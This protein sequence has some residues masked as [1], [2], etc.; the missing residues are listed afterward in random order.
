VT[1]P[2]F[3]RDLYQGTAGYYD[4]C[5]LPYPGALTDDLAHRSGADGTGRLLD[6]AC[7]TGQVC[8]TLLDRFAEVW[9]VDQEPEMIAVVRDK[10]RAAGLAHVRAVAAPAEGLAAPEASF[11]LVTIGNAFHRLPRDAVA[12]GVFRWL[13]PGG[14][15][16][17]VWSRPPWDGQQPWQRALAR[18][19]DRWQARAGAGD[20]I[21]AGYEQDRRE[22]PDQVI[23]AA[24]GFETAG[25]YQFPA[26]HEWTPEALA[27]FALST[28][29]L[30]AAALGTM[31]AG[32]GDDLR[33]ELH[34]CEPSGRLPQTIDFA[35]N[36]ARRP[37]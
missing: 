14:L 27:G 10:A 37:A 33:R 22:R 31:A 17:L 6:L 12:A 32:F 1:G 23:L 36:L 34:A 4:R 24:A 26:R 16:A 18:T 29:V 3:R 20:R 5:R 30:S 25:A 35:Y 28:S 11:D 15:L 21:P 7:G 19:M 13:R 8:F 9:A 2:V